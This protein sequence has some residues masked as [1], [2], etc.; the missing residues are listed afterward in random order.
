MTSDEALVILDTI[1]TQERLNDVQELVFRQAWRGESYAKIAEKFGY[2]TSHIKAVGSELWQLLSELT[3][4]KTTKSNFQAVLR[5]YLQKTS[6]VSKSSNILSNTHNSSV[7][8]HSDRQRKHSFIRKQQDWGEAVD[9]PVF[10]GRSAELATLEQWMLRDRC[11]LVA[12]LGMGGIGKTA[13]SVKLAEQIQEQFEYV[14]WRSLRNAPLIEDILDNL[15]QILA[16]DQKAGIDLAKNLEDKITQLI[17]CLRKHRCLLVLDNVDA[18]L[19]GSN[20]AGYYREGY[21]AYGDFLRRVGEIRH[22]SCLILT[23]REKLRE[24]VLLEGEDLP[25]RSLQLSGLKEVEAREIFQADKLSLS[26]SEDEWN[27]LVKHYVGNPL[28]LKIVAIT[29]RESFNSNVSEF[30][31]QNIAVFDD[32]REVL[33]QQFNRLSSLEQEIMY[34]L[35]ILREPVSLWEVEEDII[36]L[37][38]RSKLIEAFNS[39]GRRFL[40]EKTSANY[41][42]QPVV[43]E[44]VTERLIDQICEEIAT[45]EASLL[46]SHSLI[47]ATAKDYIRETQIRVILEAIAN[48]LKATLGVNKNIASK[49]L[50]IKL[51]LQQEPALLGYGCGNIINLLHYL[52]IDLTD[53]DFSH[54]TV[55]QANLRSVNLHNVNFAHADLAK[56]AFAETLSGVSSTAF[57]PDG[58]LLATGD[59]NSEVRLWQ[60]ADFRQLC[61]FLG[62]TGWVWSVSFSPDS[63]TLVS[64]SDDRTVRLWDVKTGQCIKILSGHIGWIWSVSFSPDGKIFASGSHDK[65][66]RLWDVRDGKCLRILRGHTD[67]VWSISFSPDGQTLASSSHDKTVKLWSIHNGKCLKTLRGHTSWVLSVSFSPD[68][69]TLASSSDDQTVRLWNI[70]DGKCLK[71]LRG[72]TN[73]L[74]S[75]SFSPDGSTLASS[76][77]DQTVRLWNVRDGKCLKILQGHTDLV[78]SVSFSPDG[79][80]LASSSHDQTV[81][82]WDTHNGNCLRTLLGY[83]SWVLSVSFSPDGQ[84]LASSSH[85]RTVRLWDTHNGNC[86][87]TLYGH[88][89][90]LWSV[91]FSPD[92]QT[93]ASSSDDQTVK[94][95]DIND[96]NCLRTLHG[97]TGWVLS[98]SFSRDGQTLASGGHDQTVRLWDIHDG[99]CLRTLHGH[100]GWVLSVS[101]SR[102]GQTL[103]SSS[104]DQTVRL[105]DARNGECL[106]ILPGHTDLVWS[107]SFSSDGKTLASGSHDQTVRLWD[108]DDGKCLKTLQGHTD[109]VWSVSFSPDG[110]T[111]A[112]GS[113]DQ[114][115]RLWDIQ[116]GEC[117][118]ALHS[119][120]NGV[121][122]VAFSPNGR[123]LVSCSQDETIKL[124]DITTGE[125]LKTLRSS[126]LYEGMNITGATGLTGLQRIT[127]K[128]LGAV[129]V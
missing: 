118:K 18:V 13:L 105:W 29:I 77:D 12:L 37:V 100:T 22:Q 79:T 97:H 122:S 108:I 11:R 99:N 5:R 23:S 36:S 51:K 109:L 20:F 71:I 44:Y 53:Y 111:L 27:L 78:W 72:H 67:V 8:D 85:D 73:R 115:V 47:K 52:K 121:R 107:V 50:Q 43:M 3:G 106:R 110:K 17:N 46:I 75:V 2:S 40:I 15:L 82:L 63:R 62:H 33:E 42:Q 84:T 80:T 91:S 126:R 58:K 94:L 21:Q 59:M 64:S 48:R 49:L 90:R 54:L 25:V 101:F 34:W 83:R 93:I 70:R 38:S 120:T 88:T 92:G 45:E 6:A 56:S 114:T 39:L 69:T 125:C 4:E 24:L 81:R 30:L 68:A 32:I 124:W 117:L 28:A 76:S 127:L 65:T 19:Q 96:G 74:W 87:K 66:V 116:N 123:N 119:H 35:A 129:E 55:W 86:V 113:Q 104:H 98:A 16:D 10:Y 41:T 102:D 57:S 9:I 26:G 95:W 1:L 103:A 128:A 89:G 31:V 7:T 14:I 112:S 60:V 61:T